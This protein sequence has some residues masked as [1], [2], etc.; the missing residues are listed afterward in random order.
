M[1]GRVL[2]F[3]GSEHAEVQRLLPWFVK[4]TL[5]DDVLARVQRHLGECARCQRD[6]DELREW[7]AVLARNAGASDAFAQADAATRGLARLRPRL[8]APR[9]PAPLRSHTTVRAGWRRAPAWVRW[10]V[11]AQAAVIALAVGWL[12]VGTQQNPRTDASYRTLSDAP[13]P[14]RDPSLHRLIVV[15]AP[16]AE[17]SRVRAL[18]QANQARVIDGPSETGAYVL[19]VPSARAAAVRTAL[20]ASPDVRLAESLDPAQ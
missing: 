20:R 14:A 11:A 16:H 9:A 10:T 13:A 12:F 7:T 19:S 4:D 2:P 18:L 6:A 8:Q 17:E 5:E 1:S 15:F 3:A